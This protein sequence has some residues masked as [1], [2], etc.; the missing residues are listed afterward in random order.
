MMR[1]LIFWFA[2]LLA[3]CSP[4]PLALSTMTMPLPT[5]TALPALVASST[6]PLLTHTSAATATLHPTLMPTSTPVR[7][8]TVTFEA[9]LIAVEHPHLFGL[10]FLIEPQT[11]TVETTS[12]GDYQE[13]LKFLRHNTI[14]DCQL[15]APMAAGLPTPDRLYRKNIGDHSYIVMDYS[16]SSL[17]ETRNRSLRENQMFNLFGTAIT[18][19][20]AALEDVLMDMMEAPVFYGDGTAVPGITST[21]RPPLDFNCNSKPPQLRVDDAAYIIADGIWLRNGPQRS[22]DTQSRL[23]P[24]YAPYHIYIDGGPVCDND[25]IF[26]HVTASQLGEGGTETLTGWMAEANGSEYFLENLYP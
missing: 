18:G 15:K 10:V 12:E 22:E 2:F 9:G 4:T 8:P 20:R 19:C 13:S 23:L 14:P 24:K 17:Y 25:Y 16:N 1:R 11:W 3:A 6:A 7:P 26:W 21:P 5:G